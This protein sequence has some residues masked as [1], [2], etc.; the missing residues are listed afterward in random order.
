MAVLTR[1][2]FS[3]SVERV[4]NTLPD[5]I[6]AVGMTL[7]GKRSDLHLLIFTDGNGT[8]IHVQII[9]IDDQTTLLAMGPDVDHLAEQPQDV[10]PKAIINK[11]MNKL[12]I[13]C[14]SKPI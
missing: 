14:T 2:N 12:R 5:A 9:R 1:E 7:L 13:L 10:I 3:Y 4:F 11:V 8:I 6:E